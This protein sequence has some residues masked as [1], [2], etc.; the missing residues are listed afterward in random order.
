MLIVFI[1]KESHGLRLWL[2]NRNYNK[3]AK[4]AMSFSLFECKASYDGCF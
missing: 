4:G 3:K 2:S 1:T